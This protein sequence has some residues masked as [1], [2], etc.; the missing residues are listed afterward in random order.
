MNGIKYIRE[1]SNI[2][3]YWLAERIGV[4]RQTVTQWEKGVRKPNKEHLKWLCEFYGIEE[5]WFGE[6]SGAEL[7]IL[8]EMIMYEHFEG[9][10][11]YYTFIPRIDG[12]NESSFKCGS[13][14]SMVSDK[15]TEL[16]KEEKQFIKDVERYLFEKHSQYCVCDKIVTLKR[17]MAEINDFLFLMDVVEKIGNEG[18]YLKVP[19]RYEI[20][21]IFFA[22]LV[23]SGIYSYDEVN[24]MYKLDSLNDGFRQSEK[25]RWLFDPEYMNELVELMTKH[26]NK[27]KKTEMEACENFLRGLREAKKQT[28]SDT[29]REGRKK[30]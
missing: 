4:T 7:D 23:A 1:K 27:K 16:R 14:D 3:Q 25:D 28:D 11:E 6:L 15:Y 21:T 13:V 20:K 26:W 5:K 29:E 9:D 22:T 10:K 17:K 18:S 24:E 30:Q 12:W 2:T 8:N 19:F